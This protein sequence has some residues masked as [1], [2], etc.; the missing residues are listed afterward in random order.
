MAWFPV[1]GRIQNQFGRQQLDERRE[2]ANQKG[3]AL[4]P[5]FV[6]IDGRTGAQLYS[7]TFHEQALYSETQNTPALSAYFELMDKLLPGFL[8]TLSHAEDSRDADPDQIAHLAWL[9]RRVLGL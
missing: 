9:G 2:F 4:A 8:S 5:K 1:P 7:E 3:F 6:F